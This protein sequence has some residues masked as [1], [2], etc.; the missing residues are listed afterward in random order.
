MILDEMLKIDDIVVM[1]SGV[2]MSPLLTFFRRQGEML[3][4]FGT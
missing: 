2:S 4:G 3:K 1:A